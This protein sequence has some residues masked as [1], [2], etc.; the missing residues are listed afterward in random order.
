[1]A[2]QTTLDFPRIIE[3]IRFEDGSL[4]P[5]V[6]VMVRVFKTKSPQLASHLVITT[7]T[8]NKIT[9]RDLHAQDEIQFHIQAEFKRRFGILY[10]RTPN[11]F[12]FSSEKGEIISNSKLGQSFLAVVLKRSGD[13]RSRQ[14]KI[15]G[16]YY[17]QVFNADTFIETY[18]L[19]YRIVQYCEKRKKELLGEMSKSDPR[20]TLLANGTYHLARMIA[21]MWRK[22]DNWSDLQAIRTDLERI[23]DDPT[24]LEP[25]HKDAL[26][27]LT[28]IFDDNKEFWQDPSVALKSSE[29]ETEIEKYLYKRLAAA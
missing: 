12:V 14:Y 11:E 17:E 16:K 28:N 26:Q 9:S 8:Q 4:H 25:Y 5:D 29:L 20:R 3:K 7:N 18:L 22:G 24:L 15:W 13:A 23:K 2:K 6:R 10:E 27:Q 19:A 21:F 1:L